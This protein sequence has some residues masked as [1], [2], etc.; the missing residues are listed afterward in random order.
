MP[1]PGENSCSISW[2][3]ISENE[4]AAVVAETLAALFP[5]DPPEFLIR[6]PYGYFDVKSIH[7]ELSRAG[8]T[9]NEA[10]SLASVTRASSPHDAAIAYCHGTPLRNEIEARDLSRVAEAT[11]AVAEALASRFGNGPR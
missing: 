5:Q 11:Q 10:T 1:K 7:D 2:D 8:F 4:F 9:S 3:R 6:I